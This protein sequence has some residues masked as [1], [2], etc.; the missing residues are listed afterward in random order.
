MAQTESQGLATFTPEEAVAIPSSVASENPTN[1]SQQ[2]IES[3][4]KVFQ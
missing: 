2:P 3:V 4:G 1:V